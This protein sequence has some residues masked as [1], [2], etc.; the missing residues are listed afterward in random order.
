MQPQAQLLDGGWV[1]GGEHFDGS[2]RQVLRN[3]TD[4]EPFR[5]ET[6]AVPEIDSLNFSRDEETAAD[7][8][9]LSPRDE[10]QCGSG[11][12]ASACCPLATALALALA[13]AAAA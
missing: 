8:V 5:F 4:A 2:I 1:A 9:Q 13:S 3:P 10:R 11:A 7:F 12:G 6:R